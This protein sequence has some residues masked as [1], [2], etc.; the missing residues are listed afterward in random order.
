MRNIFILISIL[1][2]SVIAIAQPYQKPPKLVVGIVIDQMRYEYIYRYWDKFG[3]TGF[4]KLL[5]EGLNCRNTRFNYVPTYTGPG[6]ASIYTGSTPMHHGIIANDWFDKQSNKSIYCTTDTT[7]NTLGAQ[8]NSGKHSPRNLLATTITDQL[9][10][11]SNFNSKCIGIALKDRG[12][13][14][15]AGQ[16]ANAAYWFDAI[17]GNF[18]SSSYYMD[19]LPTWVKNFNKQEL[20]KNYLQNTWNTFLPIEQYTESF[21]D[22]NSYE[23]SINAGNPSVFPYDLASISSKAGFGIIRY[24]P[25]GNTITTEMA[26]TTIKEEKLGKASTTDFLCVSYSTPDYVGHMYGPHSVEMQDIYLRLDKEL[27]DF[28]MFLEKELGKENVLVFLTADHGGAETP[29][30]LLDK[31][32]NAGY[33]P[34]QFIKDTVNTFL[35]KL[36]GNGNWV[37]AYENQQ[38]YLN[39]TAIEQKISALSFS[40]NGLTNNKN[41]LDKAVY[42]FEKIQKLVAQFLL[43]MKGVAN[44]YTSQEIENYF[45]ENDL[46]SL[47]KNGYYKKRSGDVIIQFEP[48]WMEYNKFG[49]T[50]GSEY[51]YDTHVPLLW[52][53]WKTPKGKSSV[54]KVNITDIA[55]TLSI[56]L[57]ASFPSACIGNPIEDFFK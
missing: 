23:G 45:H 31:N 2:L 53:G 39:K 9:K 38:V 5:N 6:H 36:I 50:H 28:F 42:D 20:P 1:L 29:S 33:F 15:P 16:L 22:A 26:K 11:I 32:A 17:S 43:N 41:S 14:L 57:N 3:N 4:K 51:S 30:M 21:P 40:G 12:A 35:S 10:L 18:V 25:W 52:W 56:I 47:I 54:S 37:N 44:T 49:T 24:T 48:G 8:N 13:I 19:S 55:P 34:Y 7:V 27:G 46:A